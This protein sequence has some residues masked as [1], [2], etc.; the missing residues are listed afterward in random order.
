MDASLMWVSSRQVHV[1]GACSPQCHAALA[2]VSAHRQRDCSDDT[3]DQPNT[4]NN[5]ASPQRVSSKRMYMSGRRSPRLVRLASP[6]AQFVD[7]SNRFAFVLAC[8]YGR[9]PRAGPQRVSSRHMYLSGRHSPRLV[10]LASSAAP[11]TPSPF[12]HF[13][14]WLPHA[15]VLQKYMSTLGSS[16]TCLLSDQNTGENSLAT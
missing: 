16:P 14:H 3:A 11:R 9:Q 2:L 6:A 1:I 13:T 15:A 4:T 5:T 12:S 10:W 7:T 8:Q